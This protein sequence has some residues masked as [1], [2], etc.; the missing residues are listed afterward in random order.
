MSEIENEWKRLQGHIRSMAE[1]GPD[2]FVCT[3]SRGP[4]LEQIHLSAVAAGLRK[5]VVVFARLPSMNVSDEPDKVIWRLESR[6][7]GSRFVWFVDQLGKTLVT[8]ELAQMILTRLELFC[9]DYEA[10]IQW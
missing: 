7:A 6:R 8:E 5:F 10:Q 9:R 2:E 4:E 3:P 1:S